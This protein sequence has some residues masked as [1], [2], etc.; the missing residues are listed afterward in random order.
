M[1]AMPDVYSDATEAGA[2]A[3]WADPCAEPRAM[4]DY[5]GETPI[6]A[7]VAKMLSGGVPPEMIVLAIRTA[8][9]ARGATDPVAERRRAFDR[10]RKRRASKTAP[11]TRSEPA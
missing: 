5:P 7:M 3:A 1:G 10:E 11:A 6:A 4:A 9:L 2:A 8:E